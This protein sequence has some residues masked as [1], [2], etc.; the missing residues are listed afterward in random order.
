MN[1]GSADA[2]IGDVDRD[3]E[4]AQDGSPIGAAG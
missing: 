3:H 4:H 1:A 2:Y